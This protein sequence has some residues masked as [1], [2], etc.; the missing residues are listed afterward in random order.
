MLLKQRFRIVFPRKS[1]ILYEYSALKPGAS[2]CP[3]WCGGRFPGFGAARNI[4]SFSGC[5]LTIP[6]V[7]VRDMVIPSFVRPLVP[8][9]DE[10]SSFPAFTVH[11]AP[12]SVIGEN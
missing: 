8:C 9:D 4:P 1:F 7:F 11:T 5:T 10:L 2:G 3:G 6:L 12:E